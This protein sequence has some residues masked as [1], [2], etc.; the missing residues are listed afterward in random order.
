MQ[1][2]A[3]RCGLIV[4]LCIAVYSSAVAQNPGEEQPSNSQEKT[5]YR[6]PEAEQSRSGPITWQSPRPTVVTSDDTPK[7]SVYQYK[8]YDPPTRED[9]DACQQRR[10]AQASEDQWWVAVFGV[11]AG[12]AAAFFTGWAAIEAGKAARASAAAAA[13]AAR[14][15]EIAEMNGRADLRAWVIVTINRIGPVYRR[16]DGITC[17]KINAT[18]ENTG[19]TP[20]TDLCFNAN[21]LNMFDNNTNIGP[22]FII[23]TIKTR[24]GGGDINGGALGPG[25]RRHLIEDRVIQPSSQVPTMLDGAERLNFK[26]IIGVVYRTVIPNFEAFSFKIAWITNTNGG[27]DVGTHPYRIESV[28]H[29]VAVTKMR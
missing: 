21:V 7:A 9:A 19:K 11:L 13:E 28:N 17:I 16:D 2:A 1:N 12:V 10:S 18:L 5:E 3:F 26:V 29:I 14:S 4:F 25:E 15:N 8:C 24:N 20:A 22:N 6:E 23:E 27:F